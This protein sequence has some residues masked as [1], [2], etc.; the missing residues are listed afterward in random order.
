VSILG[1]NIS[2][3]EG[4]TSWA[5][6]RI[7]H[8]LK[9]GEYNLLEMKRLDKIKDGDVILDLGTNIGLTAIIVA[10]L[11]P[12]VTVIGIEPVPFNYAAALESPLLQHLSPHEHPI[13][14]RKPGSVHHQHGLLLA[15]LGC[16]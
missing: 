3:Y 4:S 8:E 14:L 1:H 12:R 2:F 11:W 7:V 6:N 15:G 10:K 5:G 13:Q 9:T 16:E